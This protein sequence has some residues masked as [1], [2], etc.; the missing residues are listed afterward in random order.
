MCVSY[1][2]LAAIAVRGDWMDQWMNEWMNEWTEKLAKNGKK[3][4]SV[5]PRSLR[6]ES[7]TTLLAFI[8]SFY[9]NWSAKAL[10]SMYEHPMIDI[11]FDM[12]PSI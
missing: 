5:W 6:G 12:L 3:E 9:W 1:Q 10:L 7:K 2:H 4:R 11:P 8:A